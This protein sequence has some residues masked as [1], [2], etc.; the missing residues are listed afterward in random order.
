MA[1][2]WK[3]CY[4][5]LAI[6]FLYYM[7]KWERFLCILYDFMSFY[8]FICYFSCICIFILFFLYFYVILCI[9]MYFYV[10]CWYFYVFIYFIVGPLV[11]LR[12]F[13]KIKWLTSRK[14][15]GSQVEFFSK[16]NLC[17]LFGEL[18]I[19]SM[20]PTPFL[21]SKFLKNIPRKP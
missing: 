7:I 1:C 5:L 4:A 6:F 13:L 2:D 20:I 19:I 17:L 14:L 3:H 8:V 9:L 11:V 21:L 18:I 16:S 10:S 15:F 12:Y